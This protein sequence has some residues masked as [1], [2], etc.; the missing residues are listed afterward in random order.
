MLFETSPHRPRAKHSVPPASLKVIHTNVSSRLEAIRD[1]LIGNP[2]FDQ[3]EIEALQTLAEDRIP[4][5][6]E[7]LNA[8]CS[9]A[10][11][12][13]YLQRQGV[14]KLVIHGG[15]F[16]ENLVPFV[17]G[18]SI[19]EISIDGDITDS[20]AEALLNVF[21]M[22]GPSCTTKLRIGIADDDLTWIKNLVS[23]GAPHLK[24]LVLE[25]AGD[26]AVTSAQLVELLR[27][28]NPKIESV[29]IQ[30]LD[31]EL[32]RR[33][34]MR[35][36]A[37]QDK[38]S[39]LKLNVA[40]A[41]PIVDLPMLIPTLKGEKIPEGHCAIVS[42]GGACVFC[43]CAKLN[44][45]L[46][47][48]AITSEDS[49]P[50]SDIAVQ[51]AAAF[52][53]KCVDEDEEDE[54]GKSYQGF[55][56]PPKFAEFARTAFPRGLR[57]NELAHLIGE[58]S[59]IAAQLRCQ[60]LRAFAHAY[61]LKTL[62]AADSTAAISPPTSH[63]TDVFQPVLDEVQTMGYKVEALPRV[64][65]RAGDLFFPKNEGVGILLLMKRD[66][67]PQL[68]AAFTPLSPL[69][70]DEFREKQYGEWR[71][72]VF[73]AYA[74]HDGEFEFDRWQE[75]RGA[76]NA[77]ATVFRR[78]LNIA[79][80]ELDDS[81]WSRA[82][83]KPHPNFPSNS[84]VR[85]NQEFSALEHAAF[86]VTSPELIPLPP[87]QRMLMRDLAKA[88]FWNP[89]F[90]AEEVSALTSFMS[91]RDPVDVT[92]GTKLA[93]AS[94]TPSLRLGKQLGI[95]GVTVG[96]IPKNLPSHELHLCGPPQD[97]R[98]FGDELA[99]VF[100]TSAGRGCF[101]TLCVD[102]TVS[103]EKWLERFLAQNPVK[104]KTLTLMLKHK[105]FNLASI[106]QKCMAGVKVRIV[107]DSE[108]TTTGTH[109]Q[110]ILNLRDAFPNLNIEFGTTVF[111]LGD[112]NSDEH[113]QDIGRLPASVS[114]P[115]EIPSESLGLF[116]GGDRGV[117]CDR[118]LLGQHSV[119]IKD[120]LSQMSAEE[121]AKEQSKVV[122]IQ[123]EHPVS[124]D[125]LRIL[126]YFVSI[127]PI[128][129]VEENDEN[130]EDAQRARRK[131]AWRDALKTTPEQM[132]FLQKFVLVGTPREV[133]LQTGELL[134]L[135]IYL[136]MPILKHLL[137]AHI[138]LSVCRG[139]LTL[140]LIA[141]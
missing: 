66:R 87:T 31:I 90:N 97:I 88:M 3:D 41:D 133:F 79:G 123:L 92:M 9:P 35:L 126:A 60:P 13:K 58:L 139:I 39:T 71:K 124:F 5:S 116:I 74:P 104:L 72:D 82:R 101:N 63:W 15:G 75:T 45:C 77:S 46:S 114:S 67:E 33:D 110:Q 70:G 56:Y 44:D 34:W 38:S 8:D 118:Q 96:N 95:I 99:T 89:H 107:L 29:D 19:R 43:P 105:D 117:L 106:L 93:A 130:P 76:Q 113:L 40:V 4:I 121:I 85:K 102:C 108:M 112:R 80:L 86:V 36:I 137:R 51:V 6:I 18:S 68:I 47:G 64:D 21:S 16:P 50:L 52:V 17:Q 2:H 22:E 122:H 14:E 115:S 27:K 12:K 136:N 83:L 69:Y 53:E 57:I 132:D 138:L 61:L 84:N 55:L 54:E 78:K 37:T 125:A 20:D 62:A 23:A 100:S 81:D 140:D 11:A 129:D 111:Q 73:L 119:L 24:S 134:E 10:S 65:S 98:G 28:C 131:D 49:T 141:A 1:S 7:I 109:L 48:T 91:S 42:G 25:S 59:T 30:G 103:D 120:C 127:V 94:C 32:Q 135:A 128:P 26:E